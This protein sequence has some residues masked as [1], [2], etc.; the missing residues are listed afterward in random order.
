MLLG[1]WGARQI[2][3]RY[4]KGGHVRCLYQAGG[5]PRVAHVAGTPSCRRALK[6]FRALV[7]RQMREQT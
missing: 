7:R 5:K 3:V 6:N 1:K 2:E 4:S